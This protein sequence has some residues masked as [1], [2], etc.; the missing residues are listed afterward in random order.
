MQKELKDITEQDIKDLA[1]IAGATVSWMN[2]LAP[3]GLYAFLYPDPENHGN[4]PMQRRLYEV[5]SMV[6]ESVQDILRNFES[7]IKE[8]GK[9]TIKY[10]DH[11]V[12]KDGKLHIRLTYFTDL[13]YQEATKDE[14]IASF[15]DARNHLNHKD[16]AQFY[17]LT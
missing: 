3:V 6:V 9:V 15:E 7:L 4:F 12:Q 14:I 8:F 2:A 10:Y 17:N 5:Q 1:I 13:S 11:Y 16:V